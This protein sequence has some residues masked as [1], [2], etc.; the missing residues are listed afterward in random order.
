[1]LRARL[2]TAS[3]DASREG[4]ISHMRQKDGITM[5]CPF[6][7]LPRNTLRRW[8]EA[9]RS[10]LKGG[11]VHNYTGQPLRR[12]G[13][14]FSCAVVDS[15]RQGETPSSRPKEEG[16]YAAWTTRRRSSSQELTCC[17]R[18]RGWRRATTRPAARSASPSPA[19]CNTL[20][21]RYQ[22]G[23]LCISRA[24]SQP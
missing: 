17:A 11:S 21:L 4:E 5:Y 9:P 18:S 8:P 14:G 1:M 7:D 13:A 16:T 6:S 19:V 23:R 22:V 3:N 24:F 15:L 20:R 10:I 2:R 12:Q